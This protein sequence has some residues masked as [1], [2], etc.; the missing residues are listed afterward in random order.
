M[1]TFGDMYATVNGS[2]S[3]ARV[4]TLFDA[5]FADRTAIRTQPLYI[6]D[7]DSVTA[8][9]IDGPCSGHIRQLQAAINPSLQLP[10]GSRNQPYC[11]N[12][13]L[14]YRDMVIPKPVAPPAVIL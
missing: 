5:W 14:P 12:Y 4:V 10:H 2:S 13:H 6:G 7:F 11:L 1:S 3:F 8:V 9:L